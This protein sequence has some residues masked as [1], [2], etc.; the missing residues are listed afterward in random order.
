MH[1]TRLGRFVLAVR[2]W[3]ATPLLIGVLLALVAPVALAAAPPAAAVNASLA[4]HAGI[5]SIAVA[6]PV[7]A[8]GFEVFVPVMNPDALND[9]GITWSGHDTSGN[10]STCDP[11]HPAGQDCH[12]GRDAKALAGTLTKV[13]GGNAGF[14]FTKIS[15]S[16]HALA[17]GATLGS[18]PNDWAC[19]R[20]NVTGL[21]WE[22]KTDDNGLRDKDWSYSW[23]N[24]NSPDG[25]PGT[26]DNGS[27][28]TAGRC[29]TEK[30]TADVNAQ[31]LCGASDWRMPS[32]RELIGIVD[33]GA[34][35]PSI[36]QGF[37]PNTPAS[38]FWSG[39]PGAGDTDFAWFVVF[40][41]GFVYD[42]SRS[43]DFQVRLVRGGQ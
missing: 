7:F 25:N 33:Y 11:S 29:D 31:G 34:Y 39:S 23:Y 19:T 27:C 24:T 6:D 42:D 16:G 15:N 28:Q 9:T 12:Y 26:A 35:G 20:D 13:G 8:D 37:F 32:K 40:D 18:G 17:A 1:C 5:H 41:I 3:V 4:A 2:T 14:D 30:Y 43:Y 36:D 10:A 22:V 21:I 38:Y